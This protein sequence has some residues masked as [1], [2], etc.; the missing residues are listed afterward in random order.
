MTTPIYDLPEW[1][2]SM[3]SP[4]VPYNQMVRLFEALVRA[5]IVDRDLS[6]PPGS[7]ADGAAYLVKA[8]G[9]GA[10]SGHNGELAVAVGEDAANGWLFATVA[11]DGARLWVADEAAQ[12]Q[13]SA[14]LPGWEVVTPDFPEAPEDGEIYGR[15][16]GDWEQIE[17]GDGLEDAPSDG[18]IYGRMDAAWAEIALEGTL[19]LKGG[20]DASLDPDYPAGEK[21]D[22]YIISVAGT[23]DGDPVA[24]NDLLLCIL[25]TAGGDPAYWLILHN[26]GG[27]GD[28]LAA[29]NLSDVAS[30]ST[31]R[32]N[33]GL[34][35][36]SDVQAYS[37]LLASLAALVDPNTDSLVMW[38]DSAG[39]YVYIPAG[40]AATKGFSNDATLGSGSP[41]N[42][43]AISEA[44]VATHLNNRFVVLEDQAAYDALDPPYDGVFY[45]VPEEV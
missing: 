44:A 35:I 23:I 16:D 45:F 34:A 29:N 22:T 37:S 3:A 43:A 14:T 7:C 12:I 10:W 27:A 26:G 11:V 18:K 2:A 5:T 41:D 8:A 28:L 38:D 20:F 42:N 15:K 9:T 25:D 32:T 19:D 36:G 31:S 13:Y 17:T 30:A 24:Q 39:G 21:G 33:L 4:W 40:V 1:A 6:A